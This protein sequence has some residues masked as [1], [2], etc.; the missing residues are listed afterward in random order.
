[1]LRTTSRQG[2]RKGDRSALP[3]HA[4]DHNHGSSS[5]LP[6]VP[7]WVETSRCRPKS[8]YT[9][10]NGLR[11]QKAKSQKAFRKRAPQMPNNRPMA[12][13]I[14]LSGDHCVRVRVERG[15]ARVRRP[16]QHKFSLKQTLCLLL[17]H[18]KACDSWCSMEAHRFAMTFLQ[19]DLWSEILRSPTQCPRTVS[20]VLGKTEIRQF[21]SAILSDQDVLKLKVTMYKVK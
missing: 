13:C 12:S 18:H 10:P 9:W 11:L 21:E 3:G 16:I 6:P 1:M 7:S 17:R 8:S 14:D 15:D 4:F 19:D 20:D 5:G 2:A